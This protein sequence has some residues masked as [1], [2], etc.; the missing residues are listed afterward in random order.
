MYDFERFTKDELQA[1]VDAHFGGKT[2]FERL[3][4]SKEY[5]GLT[6]YA[7]DSKFCEAALKFLMED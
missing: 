7:V 3:E 1:I 2:N 6:L 4:N 5:S